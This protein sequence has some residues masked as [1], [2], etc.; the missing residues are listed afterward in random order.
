[1]HQSTVMP[2]G[3]TPLRSSRR[4]SLAKW[5][6][7]LI[8]LALVA[9]CFPAGS[10]AGDNTTKGP[11]SGLPI[12][13]G[14]P[15][16]GGV[17]TFNDVADAP[18]LDPTK[19]ASYYTQNAVAGVVYSKLLEFKTGRD[20]P[21]GSM[22]VEGDLAESWKRSDDG[23]VWTINLRKGVKFQNI[24]PVNGREFTSADVLCTMNRIKTLP[25]VQLNR[26]DVA[27]TITAPDAYTVVFKL[28]EAF[29]AFDENLASPYMSILPCEGTTGAFDLTSTA[30][31]T[32]PFILDSW[33]R[34]QERVYKRNPDYFVAGKPYLDGV[35][36]V[37]MTDPAAAIAAFRTGQLDS[38]GVTE[39]LLPTVTTTN[40]D[41]VVRRQEA[42]TEGITFMT[43]S[44]KPFDN[45]QVRNAIALALDRKGMAK[46][47]SAAG[48]SMSGPVPSILFGGISSD[49]S[50]KLTPFD[51]TAAR[52][53]LADAGYPNGFDITMTTSDGW[54]PTIVNRAQ[55]VQEDL[56]KIGIN[57]TLKVL[58]Y[59]TFYTTW[60]AKDYELGYGYLTGM[61]SADEYLSSLYL[62]NGTR[63][64][65]NASDPKLDQMI[66]AQRGILN[67]KDR[68]KALEDISRYILKNGSNPIM[69]YTADAITVE[70]PYVHELWA[71]PQY[72]RPFL[73]SMWLGADAPG[74]K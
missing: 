50:D 19:A 7:S 36:V 69:S 59:A 52:K 29:A 42:T 64:W 6:A 71:H 55:W 34:T 63:N 16:P 3:R 5:G 13:A 9:G 22:E 60:A 10:K 17:Y 2:N 23:L 11:D 20:V 45:V 35:K 48:P 72:A 66:V 21:Y 70:H 15:Q 4:S 73:K 46:T 67:D 54:G 43:E 8:G 24:A 33:K 38:T 26:I 44:V 37:I 65:F 28:K 30:I 51:P 18:T 49:E 40:P 1:M 41:T 57:V 47:F 25:G 32:G 39:T 27:E 12:D 68:E 61:M 14:A 53:L 62:G 58:D 74:R 31:G 56:K